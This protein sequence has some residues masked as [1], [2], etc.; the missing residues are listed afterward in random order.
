MTGLLYGT[1]PADARQLLRNTEDEYAAAARALAASRAGE[2]LV[3]HVED[4]AAA[5]ALG[6]VRR[7]DE[8]LLQALEHSLAEHARAVGTPT[9]GSRPAQGGGALAD[10][11]VHTVRAVFERAREVTRRGGRQA[12]GAAEGALRETA[13]PGRMAEDVQGAV[14]REEVCRLPGSASSAPTRSS[15][16]CAHCPSRN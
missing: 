16:S 7:Q 5:D 2:T 6:S 12:R 9:N 15:S 14:T 3:E 4:Q 11:A 1:G 10:A 8:E 13:Q